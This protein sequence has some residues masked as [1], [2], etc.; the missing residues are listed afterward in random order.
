MEAHADLLFGC[1]FDA[2]FPAV[3]EARAAMLC[4]ALAS[5]EDRNCLPLIALA[6]TTS[7]GNWAL[8]LR[9]WEDLKKPV[10]ILWVSEVR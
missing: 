10:I 9:R 2:F 4:Q 7:S 3:P 6:H 5:P 8:N 1:S